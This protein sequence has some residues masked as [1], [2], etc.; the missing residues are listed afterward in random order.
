MADSTYAGRTAAVILAGGQGTRLRSV[1]ADRQKV[2]SLVDER[3]FLTFLL[4][5]VYDSGIDDIILAC[6]HMAE[7]VRDALKDFPGLKYS[8]E[9]KPLGTGG[10]LLQALRQSDAQRLLVMNGDSFLD[11]ALEK[12]LHWFEQHAPPAAMVLTKVADVSR[13][14]QVSLQGDC[15]QNFQEKQVSSWAGW[16]NAGIYCFERKELL[17]LPWKGK[18]SLERDLFPVLAARQQLAGFP[19]EGYFI[20]IGTP[21]SWQQAQQYFATIDRSRDL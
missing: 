6:G 17:N 16:I 3:P 15:I 21:E 18:F 10:A 20:D 4:Q 12:F 9:S 13:Y 14:G 8:L 19:Y 1:V 7:T 11:L 5:K 2:V